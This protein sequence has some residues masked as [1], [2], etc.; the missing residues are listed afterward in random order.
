AWCTPI[1]L[2]A[3]IGPSRKLQCRPAL[4]RSCC[5]VRKA[6]LSSQ[7][8]RISFSSATKSTLFDTSLNAMVITYFA[9]NL[10]SGPPLIVQPARFHGHELAAINLQGPRLRIN[11]D[12]TPL[13]GPDHVQRDRKS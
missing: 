11:R 13:T 4:R 2:F 12:G 9:H 6:P 1:G 7:S 3:V 10:L 5:S 8:W